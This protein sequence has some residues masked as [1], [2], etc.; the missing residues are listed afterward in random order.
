MRRILA[1]GLPLLMVLTFS[2]VSLSAEKGEAEIDAIL[3]SAEMLF[4]SMKAANY[5]AV[6]NHLTTKSKKIIVNDTY[7][8]IVKYNSAAKLDVKVS[9]DDVE[10]DFQSGG[11]TAKAYW[12]GYVENFHPDMALQQSKWELGE[13]Q[14]DE[15]E[16]LLRYRQSENPAHLIMKKEQGMWKVGLEESFSWS[17]R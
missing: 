17:R 4:K 9:K 2:G 10:R 12:D 15:A 7:K 14:K 16:I 1:L 13:V 5:G 3:T 11:A 6:W 8:A